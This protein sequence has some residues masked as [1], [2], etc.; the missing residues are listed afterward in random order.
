LD[1]DPH[2]ANIVQEILNTE[3]AY[4]SQISLL[5]KVPRRADDSRSPATRRAL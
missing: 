3:K 1:D 4:V 2:R 5:I